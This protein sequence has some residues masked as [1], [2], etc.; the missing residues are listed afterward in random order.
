[1][2]NRK[3]KAIVVEDEVLLLKNIAKKIVQAHPGFEVIGSVYNGKEALELIDKE[4]PDVVFT[5]IR[6][7]IMDGLQLAAVLQEK[8]PSITVVIVSGY[9]DFEYARSAIR[10]GVC[11]YLLKPVRIE[12]LTEVLQKLERRT[13]ALEK[14]QE[15]KILW[16]QLRYG[17][18]GEE[19]VDFDNYLSRKKFGIF[20]ICIGNLYIRSNQV[21]TLALA[22]NNWENLM[23]NLPGNMGSAYIYE[24]SFNQRLLLLEGEPPSWKDTE[25]Y[26]RSRLLELFPKETV[27]ISYTE[28]AIE[29]KELFH[30]W[31]KVSHQLFTC[32]VI[33]ESQGISNEISPKGGNPAVLS[34][35]T[36][37]HIQTL[38]H[39]GNTEG[40][41]NAILQLFQEWNK[42][43]VT[44]QRMEKI[45][46]QIL[47]L[48][49]QSLFFSEE[50]YD[51]MFQ[52]VFGYLETEVD[53]HSGAEKVAEE[54]ARWAQQKQEVPSE[55]ESAI[56]QMYQYIR[57]HYT[58]AINLSAL[59]ERYHFNHSYI[60][61][62][63]KKLKGQ[64][65]MKMINT[66]R[67]EDAKNM[68]KNES[69]SVREISETL[70]FTDQ[71]YFSRIFKETTGMTP[72]EYRAHI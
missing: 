29:G 62:L 57:K 58:E 34:T 68:L 14:K 37:N 61:R 7:P 45:L 64:T 69:L 50:D 43:R 52:N 65:P 55:I 44:Q 13:F 16:R 67:M 70:G 27:N 46:H 40:I 5:D 53:L 23:E 6:M 38:L 19:N 63:F 66:L 9:S 3:I 2:K 71:H 35:M 4:K 33:G 48:F 32:L 26:L 39:S 54:L 8:Y 31:Q 42:D 12:E 28:Q 18:A 59:S 24:V 36:I 15:R 49:H 56:E 41:R 72:K 1:M 51:K 10:Y 21:K 47:I 30:G 25:S 22:E 20:L 17:R 11:N 60:T